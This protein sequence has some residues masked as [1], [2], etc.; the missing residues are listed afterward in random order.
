MRLSQLAVGSRARITG[1]ESG[2][3]VIKNRLNALGIVKGEMTEMLKYTLVKNTYEV[4]VGD[5]RL[6]LRKEEAET[7]EITL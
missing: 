1:I 4:R 2:D 5:T 7:V 6:A 3:T